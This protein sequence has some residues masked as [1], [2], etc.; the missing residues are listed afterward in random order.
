[1]YTPRKPTNY[2]FWS[3][4][5]LRIRCTVVGFVVANVVHKSHACMYGLILFVRLSAGAIA[6][7]VAKLENKPKLNGRKKAVYIKPD[8]LISCVL[9]TTMWIWMHEVCSCSS[10]CTHTVHSSVGCA[11]LRTVYKHT[12][13]NICVWTFYFRIVV[14]GLF[15][16]AWKCR[17]I[18][19]CGIYYTLIYSI[20]ELHNALQ[21]WF[22]QFVFLSICVKY[23][24]RLPSTWQLLNYSSYNW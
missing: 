3:H 20:F 22:T 8:L 4:W 23:L 13:L 2:R 14:G 6:P 1:M 17:H 11:R 5:H 19:F 16:R 15:F 7:R 12:L 24:A 21:I 10:Q 9:Y 18:I